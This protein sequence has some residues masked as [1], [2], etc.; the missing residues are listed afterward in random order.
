MAGIYKAYDIRGIYPEQ[1]NEATAE[2]I[3]RA[4]V[5][6]LKAKKVVIG[7]DMRPHSVP[8]FQALVK[9]ITE[10]GADVIDLGMCSTPM[11]YHANGKLKADA[12]V[13]ITASHNPAEW[14]GF[15][16]C[17]ADAVPLSGKSG[18]GDIE[19]LVAKDLWE[20]PARAGSVS[21]YN[22]ADEYAKF[23]RSHS[24]V[25]RKLKVVVDYAN[26]MGSREIAGI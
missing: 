5:T 24:K 22:I 20:K 1:L 8:L 15:K 16:I 26:A 2:K 17:R 9:G 14:N 23:L 13:M 19:A 11:C 18:I 7:R 12:S 4:I 21:S 10:Q 25:N 6:F 3:G